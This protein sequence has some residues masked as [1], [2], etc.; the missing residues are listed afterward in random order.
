M[1]GRLGSARL[2]A[3]AVI[4]AI[5]EP[6]VGRVGEVVVEPYLE[7][8]TPRLEGALAGIGELSAGPGG[9][10]RW[11]LHETPPVPQVDLERARS[12]AATGRARYRELSFEEAARSLAAA[13]DAYDRVLTSLPDVDELIEV[14]LDLA[15]TL[16][17]A[18][19]GPAADA[20]LRAVARLRPVLELD[21][22]RRP[23]PLL[24]A[25]ARARAGVN[26]E[27]AARLRLE[28]EPPAT[29]IVDGSARGATPLELRLPAGEHV[30]RLRAPGHVDHV[31]RLVLPASGQVVH[32]ARLTATR[33]AA[34]REHLRRALVDGRDEL[35]AAVSLGRAVGAPLVLVPHVAERPASCLVGLA[36][37]DAAAGRRVAL[38][39]TAAPG[40]CA[41]FPPAALAELRARVAQRAGSHFL[42]L[43][44]D[45]LRRDALGVDPHRLC[46]IGP[47]PRE[48]DVR[49]VRSTTT[50]WW[51]PWRPWFWTVCLV[52]LGGSAA[53]IAYGTRGTVRE[54]D[55]LKVMIPWP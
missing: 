33:S 29:A 23:P 17:D 44:A 42:R 14:R 45:P 26:L 13:R 24:E 8:G 39:V 52:V 43:A 41:A 6:V 7:P 5:S 37:V 53:A 47:R 55:R 30:V 21:P 22:A 48:L 50:P 27:P 16:L 1:A 28:A 40:P 25:L 3:V 51:S 32:R 10:S 35:A 36:L 19:L 34:A 2:L 9:S 12:L 11:R 15:Q 31:T 46:G 38:G 4:V 18:N 20:E 49:P 54:P